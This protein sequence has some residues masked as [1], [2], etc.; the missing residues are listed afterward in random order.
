MIIAMIPPVARG[1][2]DLL[3]AI[4]DGEGYYIE[5]E[6]GYGSLPPHHVCPECGS[7][8]LTQERLLDSSEIRHSP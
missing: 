2:A 1:Y 8:E 3:D 7:Q 5:C 4:A 6:N